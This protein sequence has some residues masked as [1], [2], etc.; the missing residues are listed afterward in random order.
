[1]YEEWKR[2]EGNATPEELFANTTL[3]VKPVKLQSVR[4]WVNTW[5]KK[6][7]IPRGTDE[8][9]KMTKAERRRNANRGRDPDG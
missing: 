2:R 7:G 6:H 5:I 1:M 3:V 9:K 4:S 8:W